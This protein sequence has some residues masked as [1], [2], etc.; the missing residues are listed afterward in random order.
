MSPAAGLIGAPATMAPPLASTHIPARSVELTL[1][2]PSTAWGDPRWGKATPA[3]APSF[4][5]K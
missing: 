2:L 1:M 3:S 5:T 4:T